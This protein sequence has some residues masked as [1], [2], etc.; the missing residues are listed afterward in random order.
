M[1]TLC[2]SPGACSLAPHILLEEIGEPFQLEL[3]STVDGSTRSA[4]HLRLNPKG[5][6]PVLRC[7]HWAL[8]ET[9]AIL[10][11]LATS[12]P[13]AGFLPDSGRGV[14][15]AVEWS[16]WLSTVHAS[17]VK[18]IWRPEGFSPDRA[19]H[20]SIVASGRASLAQSFALIDDR[21]QAS[22]W[23]VEQSLSFADVY[24]LVFY[25]WA[26]RMGLDMRTSYAA[27]TR[28]TLALSKRPA[29][30]RALDTECISLWA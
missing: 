12:Y 2:Y 8:T 20:D 13:E 22:A 9:P 25:R 16:N 21:L 1:H 28:H 15:R 26:C 24:L 27:W 18:Q 6:V 29:V 14:A 3:V 4:A 23:M 10:L 5:R 19:H 7:E 11:H 30:Q 17:A